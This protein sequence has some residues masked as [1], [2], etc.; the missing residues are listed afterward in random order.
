[1]RLLVVAKNFAKSKILHDLHNAESY[2]AEA[3]DTALERHRPL[4]RFL[5]RS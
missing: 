4:G 2:V 1:M 5:Y 3:R